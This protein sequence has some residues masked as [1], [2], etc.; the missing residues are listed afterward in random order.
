MTKAKFHLPGLFGFFDFYEIFIQIY[1]NERE[2]F[3]DWIEIDGIFGSPHQCIWNS[4]RGTLGEY[5]LHDHIA[6]FMDLNNIGCEF[7]FTNSLLE[8]NHLYDTLGNNTLELF[9]N[10]KNSVVIHSPLLE[11]YIRDKYPKYKI[12]SS[13]T[14]C[15]TDKNEVQKELN[16]NYDYVCL[17]YNFNNNYEFLSTLPHPE[18]IEM[19]I[20][21]VCQPNCE[22]R[23]LHYHKISELMLK[24]Y[25]LDDLECPY[26]GLIFSEVQKN[27]LF[28]SVEDIKEKYLPMGITHFKIEGRVQP[29][30]D[31]IEI[32]VYYLIKPEFQME[33]RERMHG[34]HAGVLNQIPTSEMK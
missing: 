5:P 28:I 29:F 21:P 15:I 23:A 22:R 32:L 26:A 11:K 30:F 20:N 12:I 3:N 33:I 14:K 8:E 2:K 13:T 9:H 27:P 10:E 1:Q 17:D 24:K 18:K 19:L 6:Y 34:L 7:T 25:F 16:S 4:G 31:I